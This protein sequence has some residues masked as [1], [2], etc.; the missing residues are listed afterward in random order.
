MSLQLYI[1][2]LEEF[3]AKCG[4]P[5]I[6]NSLASGIFGR[7]EERHIVLRTG[8][9]LEQQILT[10]AHELTHLIAHCNANPRIHRTVCEYEAEAVERWVGAELKLAPFAEEAPDL[11]SITDDLLAGSVVRVRWAACTL[12][13]AARDGVSAALSRERL[14][15]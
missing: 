7:V 14:Q 1:E 3:S 13:D 4:A 2:R 11:S 9:S 15:A 8:L 12:V 6:R 10:L 5:V